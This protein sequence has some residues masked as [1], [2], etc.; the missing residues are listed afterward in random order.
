M[1]FN[2]EIQVL[3]EDELKAIKKLLQLSFSKTDL[4][5]NNQIDELTNLLKQEEQFIK[6]VVTLEN[7]RVQLLDTW[8]V[9]GDT[10]ISD[11]I[12]MIP[13]GKEK[14]IQLKDQLEEN[15]IQLDE[16]N[17]TNNALVRDNLEWI[18]FNINLMTSTQTPSGYG[19]D[20]E[21]S[22]TAGDLNLFDRKV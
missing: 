4:I 20:S 18:D 5:I 12:E 16:R 14:L 19:R 1:T 7:K 15:L 17:Q 3:L 6:V 22:D 21:E 9:P 8:G 10:P 11:V 13:E 2:E